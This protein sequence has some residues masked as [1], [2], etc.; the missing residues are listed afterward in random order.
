M[1][2]DLG[3]HGARDV[4]APTGGSIARMNALLRSGT[5]PRSGE[6]LARRRSAVGWNWTRFGGCARGGSPAP[7]RSRA[8]WRRGHVIVDIAGVSTTIRADRLSAQ[9]DAKDVAVPLCRSLELSLDI[10]SR[11][12]AAMMAGAGAVLHAHDAAGGRAV[13]GNA[14][15]V[16]AACRPAT[17]MPAPAYPDMSRGRMSSMAATPCRSDGL[18]PIGKAVATAAALQAQRCEP[19][20]DHH[21]VD[22]A[23]R[24]SRSRVGLLIALFLPAEQVCRRF[25]PNT[26]EAGAP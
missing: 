5:A 25:L 18:S 9:R 19:S 24:R 10:A 7:A 16:D 13:D 21:I 6:H 1:Y 12:M 2:R 4:I 14:V 26:A 23:L 8:D 22:V 11:R 3:G 17:T 15:R 20:N